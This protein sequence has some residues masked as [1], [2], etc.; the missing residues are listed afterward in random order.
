MNYLEPDYF[1]DEEDKRL[2]RWRKSNNKYGNNI[3]ECLHKSCPECKGTGK[4]KNGEM[5]IH[6]I[7]CPCPRCNLTSM[8]CHK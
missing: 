8:V 5:C 1:E 7:S 4:K 3:K 2:E 6:M